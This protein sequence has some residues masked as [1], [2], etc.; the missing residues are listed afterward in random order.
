LDAAGKRWGIELGAESDRAPGF[1]PDAPD[2]TKRYALYVE[3]TPGQNTLRIGT[4]QELDA[5]AAVLLG[6]STPEL[7]L[8]A[9]DISKAYSKTV[10]DAYRGAMIVRGAKPYIVM[11]DDMILKNTTTV[12]WAM[13]TRATVAV[14]GAKATLTDQNQILH[15]VLLSPAG[16]TFTTEDPPEPPSEQM[17]KLTGIH[18]L[19]V[20]LAEVKG[21]QTIA[22]AFAVTDPPPAHTVKP[23]TEWMPKR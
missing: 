1:N 15:A 13:H 9:V 12:T 18:V 5:K 17:K 6:H 16:A 11:Q 2:R 23:I 21:P 4:N 3:G 8:A 14:D 19:K 7:G 10:K 22:I 20:S